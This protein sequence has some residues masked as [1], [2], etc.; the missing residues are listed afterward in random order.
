M[1][2][3]V[4]FIN[5]E[6]YLHCCN[7]HFKYYYR[8]KSVILQGMRAIPKLICELTRLYTGSYNVQRKKMFSEDKRPR[9]IVRSF[10]NA[11]DVT[12]NCTRDVYVQSQ[13]GAA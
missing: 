7:V 11:R 6:R 13:S 2:Y 10:T 4:I 3:V 5:I 9:R 1:L 12:R 8:Q